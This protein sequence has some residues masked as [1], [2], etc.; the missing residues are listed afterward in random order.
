MNY[1]QLGS[2]ELHISE[3]SFGTWAIGGSWGG[4]DDR[5]A[6][7]ALSRAIEEG[8]NFF[9]TADVYGEGHSEELLAK[10]TKG[11]EDDIYI[12][13]K[14]CR[15]GD[16]HDPTSYSYESVR[17][18]CE[19]SLRRLGRE[20]IDLYQVH[21]PPADILRSGEVF[22]ALDRLREEG[23]I[24]E[25][26]V[27]VESVEEGFICLQYPNVKALQVINNLFRQKPELELIP[28]AFGQGVGILVRLPLASGLLTGKFT[29]RSTFAADDHRNFN[30]NGES[31]NVGETFAGL[32][33]EMG[34]SLSKELSWI[35]EGRTNMT[36]AALRY[37]LDNPYI[38]CV[39]PGFRNVQQVEDNL[40]AANVPGFTRSEMARLHEFYRQ[41]VRDYIRG[42]Y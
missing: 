13:T 33:F 28:K 26:G 18:F 17:R 21:C 38:T 16:L 2:T 34:V 39:I 12:A 36:S 23:K 24:R 7:K 32:A 1:R 40:R 42:P 29:E 25:Y 8:V 41:E 27:S 35:A 22:G 11:R 30:R 19:A 6:L 5:S 9:D 3:I 4:T 15:A 14:F 31:F 10:A 37:I 20:R